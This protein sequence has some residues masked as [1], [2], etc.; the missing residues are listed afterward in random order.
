M[1]F[2]MRLL[3]ETDALLEAWR[4]LFTLYEPVKKLKKCKF[5]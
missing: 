2:L 1:M 3:G 5:P 4:F